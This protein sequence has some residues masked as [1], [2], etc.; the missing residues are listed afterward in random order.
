ME[1][2]IKYPNCISN[3]EN[4][5]YVGGE[6]HAFNGNVINNLGITHIVNTKGTESKL[7]E[8]IQKTL[9]YINIKIA[10]SVSEF[11]INYFNKSNEFINNTLNENNTKK[12][13]IH[14]GGGKSR[15]TKFTMAY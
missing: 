2:R 5:I 11:V 3:S 15:S 6:M 1:N 7:D 4:R 13:L 12:T 8:N 10:D 14:C 9:K